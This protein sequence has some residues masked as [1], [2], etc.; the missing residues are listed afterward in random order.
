MLCCH[1]AV[2]NCQSAL[3]WHSC[4]LFCQH[5]NTHLASTRPSGTP[6]VPLLLNA[7]PLR[8]TVRNPVKND[9]LQQQYRAGAARH[10]RQQTE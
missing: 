4:M 1:T 7:L 8:S 5:Q 9:R 6:A 2:H 3:C 10:R